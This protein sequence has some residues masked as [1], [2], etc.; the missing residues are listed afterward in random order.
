[1]REPQENWLRMDRAE[2]YGIVSLL[3]IAGSIAGAVTISPWR[4]AAVPAVIVLGIAL[5]IIRRRYLG[6]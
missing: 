4:W 3:L 5:A 6:R 2:Q 1:M